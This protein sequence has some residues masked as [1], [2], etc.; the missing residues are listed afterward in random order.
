MKSVTKRSSAAILKKKIANKARMRA[1]RAKMT[2]DEI[3]CARAKDKLRK[4]LKTDLNNTDINA[5][6]E[7]DQTSETDRTYLANVKRKLKENL[8]YYKATNLSE[9]Y[10]K[11]IKEIKW[12]ECN[13]CRTKSIG[14]HPKCYCYREESLKNTELMELGDVPPELMNLSTI[15]QLLIAKVHPVVQVNI[16]D[17]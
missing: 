15:E 16:E 13:R 7:N 3:A 2:A 12:Q 1:M 14:L 8:K 9:L 5:L 17:K 10:A 4:S 11:M 6:Q